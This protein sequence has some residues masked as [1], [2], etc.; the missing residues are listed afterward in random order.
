MKKLVFFLLCLLVRPCFAQQLPQALQD[1]LLECNYTYAAQLLDKE[2]KLAGD[3]PSYL[4]KLADAYRTCGQTVKS[5]HTYEQALSHQ[6]DNR[7]IQRQLVRLETSLGNYDKGIKYCHDI[8][9][10]DSIDAIA[11]RLLGNCYYG[12]RELDN[13]YRSYAKA[14]ALNPDDFSTVDAF[15]TLLNEDHDYATAL[16][17]TEKYRQKD[18]TNLRINQNNAEAYFRLERY[19]EA[20][21][22]YKTLEA[23][24]DHSF[25][26][27]YFQGVSYFAKKNY[28]LAH[29][30][31]E[32]ARPTD[33]ENTSLL[34]YL[35]I[36]SAKTS[37]KKDAI[38]YMEQVEDLV[39]PSDSLLSWMY[40]GFANVYPQNH[41][42]FEESYLKM[43]E[44]NPKRFAL[45]NILALAF[46]TVDSKKARQYFQRYLQAIPE[47][48]KKK[49]PNAI[50]VEHAQKYLEQQESDQRTEDFWKGK[51]AVIIRSK[52]TS[53]K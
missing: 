39:V 47:E 10:Q 28:Y 51:P 4:I 3:N 37:W 13:A 16:E 32:M 48:E 23:S 14:Y 5:I 42:R 49:Y 43:L 20:I 25:Y 50:H 27:L 22:R 24:G 8:L 1:A 29:R 44:I 26:T 15:S 31:L 2:L 41:P 52:R 33:P 18:T 7:K 38:D 36:S 12:K 35:A 21:Q 6:P 53:E 19:D 17:M 34:Y 11:Y 40:N 9:A 46:E 30:Y 45:W